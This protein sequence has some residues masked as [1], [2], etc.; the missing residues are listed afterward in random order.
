MTR[1]RPLILW[2]H[3]FPCALNLNAPADIE[4][5]ILLVGLEGMSYNQ[6]AAILNVPVGTIRSRLSRGREALRKLL[7]ME[8]RRPARQQAVEDSAQGVDVG[9][10]PDR[11]GAAGRLL[12]RHI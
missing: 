6:A 12:G 10:L 7:G 3:L 1:W 11:L 9:R 2:L 5:L 4:T 8:E